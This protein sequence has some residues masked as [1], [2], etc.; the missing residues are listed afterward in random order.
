MA[1]N[2]LQG[3]GVELRITSD[4]LITDLHRRHLGGMGPTN[5]LSFPLENSVPGSYDNLGSVVV[6]ADAVLREAFLY[7]QDPQSH[8]IRLLTHA[9]LHLAGYE[10]GELMEEMTENTVVLMQGTH[11]VNY[12]ANSES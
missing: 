8:F 12:S 9:L 7:Q 2:Q 4:Q 11:F 10:H 3:A 5:V 6:S 1:A